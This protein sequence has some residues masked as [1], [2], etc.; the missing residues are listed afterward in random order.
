MHVSQST[1]H[2]V[3]TAESRYIDRTE[4]SYVIA[5]VGV[6]VHFKVLKLRPKGES[7]KLTLPGKVSYPEEHGDNPVSL[8]RAKKDGI[9]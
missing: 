5:E 8:K 1:A 9:I 3:L 2:G 6:G 4:E 7:G